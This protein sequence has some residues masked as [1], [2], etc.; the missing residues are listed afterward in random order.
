MITLKRFHKVHKD[1]KP[2]AFCDLFV[3][4]VVKIS[5]SL[6]IIL[7]FAACSR[8]PKG[9]IP[10]RKMQ[11][12]LTDMYLAEEIINADPYSFRTVEE[13]TALYQSVF[14]KHRVT[15]A[16]Y[17]SSL[18]W[19]GKHLDIYMQVNNMALAEVNKRIEK[20]GHIEP[21]IAYSPSKDSVDIWSIG[22]Y[23]EFYPTAISNMITFNFRESEEYTSGSIFV[24]GIH[25]WG[26]AT[27][28]STPIEVHLRAEQ[29][30]TT[31]VVKNAIT[32]DGYH[33]IILRSAPTQRIRQVYG[34]IRFNGSPQPYH[35][36]YI[37]DL[38]MIK[39]LYGGV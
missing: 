5:F 31:V 37:D 14:E 29:R 10:E 21:E 35:K 32:T 22:R 3:P 12:I 4:F 38:R 18:I 6:I 20:I 24:L 26:L 13:K 25:I 39:Y 1:L 17:D 15:Q 34:Y 11:Q 30:D 9:I 33:E 28:L 8:V 27:R 7:L 23:Y 16:V 19:Y 2:C 36:I